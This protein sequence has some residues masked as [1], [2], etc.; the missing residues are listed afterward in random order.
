VQA[1]QPKTVPEEDERANKRPERIRQK[2]S[3]NPNG[4]ELFKREYLGVPL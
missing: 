4:G 3:Q 1:E 2:V